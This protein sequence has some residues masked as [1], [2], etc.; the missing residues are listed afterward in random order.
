MFPVLYLPLNLYIFKAILPPG[1]GSRRHIF[2]RIRNTVSSFPLICHL[3]P[4]QH[5]FHSIC[6]VSSS[7][8]SSPFPPLLCLWHLFRHIFISFFFL[9][10]LSS[11]I[12]LSSSFSSFSKS[13]YL[14]SSHSFTS[15]H[16]S[17]FL[18]PPIFLY[19]YSIYFLPT[20]CNP[21]SQR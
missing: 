11:L 6:S 5:T 1:P 3:P 19:I 13:L 2:I 12:A 4:S 8:P 15:F 7:F 10:S 9:S 17:P 16:W 20:F 21:Y 14:S 18:T